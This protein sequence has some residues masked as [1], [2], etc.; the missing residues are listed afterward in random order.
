MEESLPAQ[1]WEPAA[2]PHFVYKRMYE[3]K[4][5]KTNKKP[6]LSALSFASSEVTKDCETTHFSPCELMIL[7]E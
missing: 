3:R 7:M 2:Y 6:E 4:G 5:L 1:G